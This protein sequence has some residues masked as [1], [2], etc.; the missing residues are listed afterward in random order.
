VWAVGHGGVIGRFA[1]GA[2]SA[3]IAGPSRGELRAV[4]GTP[5]GT[6]WAVGT[7]GVILRRRP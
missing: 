2:W 6:V 5:D 7:G 1:D 3:E 4:W